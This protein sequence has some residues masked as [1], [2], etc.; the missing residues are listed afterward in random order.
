MVTRFTK[1]T[2]DGY[3]I[4]GIQIIITQSKMQQLDHYVNGSFFFLDSLI[5]V[6]V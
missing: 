2:K 5:V 4:I 6:I 3:V 1:G